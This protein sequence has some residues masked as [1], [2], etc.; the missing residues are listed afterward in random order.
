LATGTNFLSVC[1][2]TADIRSKP[3][4]MLAAPATADD[5]ER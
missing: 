3:I 1:V 2:C 5:G 4:G